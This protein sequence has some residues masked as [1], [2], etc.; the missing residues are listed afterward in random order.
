MKAILTLP[1]KYAAPR[2]VI[3]SGGGSGLSR[4]LA[5]RLALEGA[6]VAI[7]NR[8]PAADVVAELRAAA[9][10]PN[11]RFE[12]YCADVADDNAIR[13]AVEHA[14]EDIGSPN[15]AINSAGIQVAAEFQNSNAEDF[16]RVVQVNLGGSRN[17][18]AAV[19]PHLTRR[20]HL[21]LMSS[22]AGLS[23]NFAYS[24]Y[25]ASKHG[26]MGL[27]SVLRIELKLKGADVSVCC[28]G[29]PPGTVTMHSHVTFIDEAS[30]RKYRYQLVFPKDAD[31]AAN[32][33]SVLTLV[34]AGLIGLK[35]G[36][37]ILWPDRDG[38]QRRLKVLSV[39][40]G[41]PNL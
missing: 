15:L 9:T 12:Y 41:E 8:K 17:F 20:G 24:A 2:A 33:I 30:D 6:N 36:Q 32:R 14:A 10:H 18:A 11:Q 29:M 22:L 28:P 21:V 27:A 16:N 38:R 1:W 37:T 23:G 4:E 5:R 19:L 31:V 34:G 7:I 35:P 25:C 40:P 26:V 39:E 13:E 3:I